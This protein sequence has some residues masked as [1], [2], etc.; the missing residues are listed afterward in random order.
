[1]YINLKTKLFFLA[2]FLTG[3]IVNSQVFD[4]DDT[5]F[6]NFS[7][8]TEGGVTI[9]S[10]SASNPLS[11]PGFTDL[12]NVFQCDVSRWGNVSADIYDNNWSTDFSINFDQP[13]FLKSLGS[14]NGSSLTFTTNNPGQSLTAP[15]CGE[16]FFGWEGVTTI[17]I[18]SPTPTRFLIDVINITDNCPTISNPNQLDFDNDGIGDACDD[19][20]DGDGV[21]NVN[22]NCNDTLPNT[23]VNSNG[24]DVILL[25]A[26]SFKVKVRGT[27]CAS[28]D[29]G[30]IAIETFEPEIS[31][32]YR[33]ELVEINQTT[34]FTTTT[35][36][37]GLSSGNYKLKIHAI[38][39]PD[40]VV[41]Y[42]I[43]VN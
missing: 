14:A 32:T 19:D 6:G 35:S 28:G 26:L 7:P 16:I 5:S 40:S 41:E 8:V 13:I 39:Y 11:N 10:L 17:N 12:G 36:F 24:C 42:N 1:M 3:I 38:P 34:D 30:S 25:G 2:L 43:T 31:T 15:G 22:D 27:D 21:L 33:A 9:T 18:S 20:L 29:S 4:F 37:N 23:T